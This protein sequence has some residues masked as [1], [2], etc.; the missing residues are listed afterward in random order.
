MRET[1]QQYPGLLE[2]LGEALRS[3]HAE[4]ARH[5]HRVRAVA[6]LVAD[7]IRLDDALR[8][9]LWCAAVLHDLGKLSVP[10]DVLARPGPLHDG[11]W[12]QIK[13][14]SAIG[15]NMLLCLSP[16]FEQAAMGIRSH[17]EHW[18]GSGYPDGLAGDEIPLI[19]RIVAVADVFD[20]ITHSRPYSPD[21]LTLEEAVTF[22]W[23]GSGSQFDPA[24]ASALVATPEI[25]GR[26]RSSR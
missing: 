24:V 9:A 5:V 13:G 11:E 25:R 14:H 4:T 22:I 16:A 2:A 3:Y 6:M 21:V 15:A 12:E 20:A 10:A 26:S 23:D 1:L 18:D 17:H 19:G 7:R 8:P